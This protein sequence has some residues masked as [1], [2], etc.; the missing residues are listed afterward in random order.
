MIILENVTKTYPKGSQPAVRGIDLYVQAGEL[1]V[2][3]GE[4]GC[5]KTT[6]LKMINRLVEPSSGRI[7]V[8]GQDTA[9]ID[10]ATLRR[11][12]GYV[13]QR[14]GLF[15]HMSVAENISITPRLLGWSK[16]EIAKRVD[17]LLETVNLNPAEYRD[18]KPDQ[19]SG[20][21]Q[22][23]VGVARAL[24]ARPKALLM[25]EPFGSLDPLTRDGLQEEL[26]R[27]HKELNL[28][29]V[30][31]T[32]D[33]TEALILADRIAVMEKGRIV[34][35]GSPYELMNKPGHPYVSR[36]INTPRR[37]TQRLNAIAGGKE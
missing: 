16:Q 37:Q 26:R 17:E 1:L 24:A 22:Q 5:G 10:R 11:G 7:T 31:V 20:G 14:I 33:I 2:L 34:G 32:H 29:I 27:L 30:L 13:I 12:I 9:N 36:L 18:R 28:T 21:Q 15:P 3:V 25:D 6:T 19:L 8:D 4:S 35:L 23:R